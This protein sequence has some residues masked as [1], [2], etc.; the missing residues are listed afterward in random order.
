ME[1]IESKKA[2]IFDIIRQ[3][4]ILQTQRIQKLEELKKLEESYH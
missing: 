2:E 4:E 1:K 3:M